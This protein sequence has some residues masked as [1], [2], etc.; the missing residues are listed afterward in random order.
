MHVFD[1]NIYFWLTLQQKKTEPARPAQKRPADR[2][3]GS[4]GSYTSMMPPYVDIYLC[5]FRFKRFKSKKKVHHSS[6]G[7]LFVFKQVL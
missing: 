3:E 1:C 4:K 7:A 6:T 2:H 5:D